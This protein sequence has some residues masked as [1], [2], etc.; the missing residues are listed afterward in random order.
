MSAAFTG[1]PFKPEEAYAQ[2][3][4]RFFELLKTLGAGAA[5]PGAARDWSSVANPLAAQ[6]EQWLRLSQSAGPWFQAAATGAAAGAA[7]GAS[8]P[9]TFGPLPLGPAAVADAGGQRL[10]ELFSRLT[11][12]QG[13]LAAHW[14]EVA[15][16]AAQRF[17]ARAAGTGP[18]ANFGES[19]KLYELWVSCA[20]EAYAATARTEEF[21]RL[22]S[23]LANVSAALLVE[24]RRP[25]EALVRAFGLPTRAEVDALYDQLK[26]LR[27]RVEERGAQKGRRA[28]PAGAARKPRAR[29]R[30]SAK[31]GRGR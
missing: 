31:R 9:W 8:P 13:A 19:L 15:R 21:A 7:P 28:T 6:F 18:A 14:A 24:Q 22:Q 23:E 26:E 10:W 17:V 25:P 16:G 5:A 1:G 2:A 11:Q 3:A 12:V 20:E 30:S 29:G 27:Q 4:D